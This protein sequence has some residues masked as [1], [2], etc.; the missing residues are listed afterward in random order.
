MAL[1]LFLAASFDP[2]WYTPPLPRAWEVKTVTFWES[3]AAMRCSI[4]AAGLEETL[5]DL[6]DNW[7]MGLVILGIGF[8]AG[9]V[10]FQWMR[11]AARG[12]EPPSW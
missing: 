3:L 1:V 12:I 10:L 11:Q 5:W 6:R 9:C 7:I 8:V 2:I 4:Q